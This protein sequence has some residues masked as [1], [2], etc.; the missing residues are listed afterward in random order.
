MLLSL[1]LGR[2]AQLQKAANN[3]PP[4]AKG[5]TGEGIAAMQEALADLGMDLSISSGPNGFDGIF[6]SETDRAVR[7]F[8]RENALSAD[9]IA[10]KLT[11]HRLDGLL[12]AGGLD[13]RNPLEVKAG[14]AADRIKPLPYRSNSNY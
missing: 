10:G 13:N 9:G 14:E 3:A 11:L 4:V 5:A 12:I 6:G 8:Q 1:R 2:H 7:R